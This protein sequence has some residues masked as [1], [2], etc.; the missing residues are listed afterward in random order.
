MLG[1]VEKIG[2][3][4]KINRREINKKEKTTPRDATFASPKPIKKSILV[5]IIPVIYSKSAPLSRVENH[6]HTA[7]N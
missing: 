7:I 2:I 1:K 4:L 3:E 5:L 6:P